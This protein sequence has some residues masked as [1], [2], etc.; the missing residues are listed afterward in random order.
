MDSAEAFVLVF[1]ALAVAG[2]VWYFFLSEKPKAVA[3]AVGGVQTFR[4]RVHGG[5]DPAT[6]VATVGTPVRIEFFRDETDSCSETVVFGDFGVSKRLPPHK[7]TVV[8][9][10]P[11]KAG[12]FGFQCGMGMLHGSL[13]VKE[14]D[15][16]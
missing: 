16:E 15:G 12:K 8:E 13:I 4:V 1:S 11:D 2:V 5:Y 7:T 10:T 6:L 9:I 3:Q 14:R